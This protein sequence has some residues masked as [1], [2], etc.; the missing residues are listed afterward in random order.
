MSSYETFVLNLMDLNIHATIKKITLIIMLGSIPHQKFYLYHYLL[1]DEQ[2]LSLGMLI[3]LQLIYNFWCIHAMFIIFL[4]A[5]GMIW[6]ELTR[7]DVVFSRTTIVVLLCR[8]KCFGMRW[9]STEIFSRKYK[10]YW[11]EELPEGGPWAP[12]GWRARPLGC[13]PCLVDSPWGP[14]TCSPCQNLLYIVKLP[15]RNIDREFC[16]QKPP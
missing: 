11:N 13:A 7:T 4:H 9:K 3:R 14:L 10:K 15:E 12:R 6:L 2:E 16:R 8:N 1:E 5:F